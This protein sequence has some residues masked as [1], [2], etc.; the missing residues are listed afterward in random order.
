M[1]LSDSSIYWPPFITGTGFFCKEDN[2]EIHAVQ[3]GPTG[4]AVVTYICGSL[5][6]AR[7]ILA[8]S[9]CPVWLCLHMSTPIEGF[10][11][12]YEVKTKSGRFFFHKR[13]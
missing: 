2:V 3:T 8:V 12:L 10:R 5:S 4:V 7:Q 13:I 9:A 6:Q 11:L 1:W